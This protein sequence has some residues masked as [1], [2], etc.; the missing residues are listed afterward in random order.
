MSEKS[1]YEEILERARKRKAREKYHKYIIAGIIVLILAVGT[2]VFL[3]KEPSADEPAAAD[4][5]QQT[6]V[7]VEVESLSEEDAAQ[8][9]E[10]EEKQ[11]VVDSYE[12]LGLVNTSGYLNVRSEPD[13][14]N[15]AN[16]I[17]KLQE[18]GACEILSTEGD[19]YYISSGEVEGYISSQYVLTGEEAREA[20][21]EHVSRMATILADK[22]NIRREP[23]QDPANVIGYA[24]RGERYTIQEETDDGWYQIAGGY[25]SADPEYT[26][27]GYA[28]NE[29]RKL[30]L[31]EMALNQYDNLVISKVSDY[32]NVRNS[33]EQKSDNSNVIGKFPGNAA[34]EILETLDGWYKIKSGSIV[35]YISSDPQYVAVGQEAKNL[36]MQYAEL[37]AIVLTDMLNVRSEPNTEST[38]WTQISK[39]ERY[40]VLDQLD[41][42]VQIELDTGDSGEG[43]EPDK[44]YISTRDNNVE[45]RYALEEAIKFSPLEEKA[46][47]LASR[48]NSLV[49]YALRFV[50]GRYVW[51]GTNPN[52]GADCSGFV[53]YVYRNSAGISL[54]R[55][56]REQA[57][58]GREVSS[59]QMQPGDLI[60]YTNSRGVVNH[61]AMYIG[62][63]QI[64]HAASSRSGIKIS[65]WNYR[66]PKTIRRY[67]E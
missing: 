25:I 34:G 5:G 36:A 19:W 44:A 45:V 31:K 43:E 63:G 21:L 67:I 57:K 20:A 49:N 52:T 29:A 1:G 64:V 26:E 46:N 38:I 61:V 18:N 11:K 39:D 30:D 59:S 51:G 7:V 58:T 2:A 9:A 50:G 17:G 33:P 8:M 15:N 41:G 6:E 55:T 35:G 56:S 37:T 60:F 48:R 32:L 16:I 13:T 10:L 53:Q 62:N 65:T 22:L 40:H 14:S 47:Q 42:W 23:V 4:A 66:K 12:N 24:L 28:L 54:P 3:R 27:A